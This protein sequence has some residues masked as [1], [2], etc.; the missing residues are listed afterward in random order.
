MD[1]PIHKEYFLSG[2]AMISIF[3]VGTD[4][5]LILHSISDN[6]EL[7]PNITVLVYAQILPDSYITLHGGFVACLLDTS[8]PNS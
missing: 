8:R 4:L 3:M 2:G 1:P 7:P 6:R 5:F